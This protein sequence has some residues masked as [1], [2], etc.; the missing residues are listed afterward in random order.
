MT[1][2]KVAFGVGCYRIVDQ[3][4]TGRAVGAILEKATDG[5]LDTGDS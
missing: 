4:N 2:L 1:V 5:V 3:T